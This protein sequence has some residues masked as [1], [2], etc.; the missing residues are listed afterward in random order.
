[1]WSEDLSTISSSCDEKSNTLF[2]VNNEWDERGS[3]INHADVFHP[4]FPT[5]VMPND[6]DLYLGDLLD[7][8]NLNAAIVG[9]T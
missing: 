4:F 1:M 2:N 9:T 7:T 8:D 6:E 5:V 3:N